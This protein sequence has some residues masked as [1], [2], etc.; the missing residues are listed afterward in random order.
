MAAP[1]L[2]VQ[3]TYAELLERCAAT[4]FDA[5]FSEDGSFTVKTIRG[6]RYWYF[7]TSTSGGRTQ[8]YV[9]PESPA[10]LEQIAHH[11][12]N[13]D[14]ERGRRTLVS[15]LV[16]SY[17]LPPPLPQV[18]SLLFA[19]ARAGTFRL[20]GVLV[21][22][23]A[24]HTYSAV[25]ARKLPSASLMT[26]D[27]DVAQFA[28]V[29]VAMGD[30]TPPMLKI[31]KDVDSSFREVLP[32]PGRDSAASYVGKGGLRVDFLTPNEGPDTDDPQ[33]LPALQTDALP[34]RFLDFLIHDAQP[35]VVLYSSGVYV[36]VPTPERFAVHKLILSIRRPAAFA[37][38]DKDLQ[39]AEALIE[40]LCEQRPGD[41]KEVWEEAYG[42]GPT[43]RK[44]LLNAMA[45]LSSKIRDQLLKAL[46]RT[47]DVLPEANVTFSDSV[48]HYD[49]S[50][51]VVSFIGQNFD[52]PVACAV[53]RETLEDHF[54]ADGLDR[55]GRMEVFR[56][57][58]PAIEELVRQKYLCWPIDEPGS[59]LL[60][61]MDVEKLREDLSRQAIHGTRQG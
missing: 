34:L 29:S 37:K 2:I 57:N 52:Q 49:F 47:R 61:S 51:E 60:A 58:R 42:R 24:Y 45:Q 1:Q 48:A 40:A 44:L 21:G 28:S 10:L 22:T 25:L 36:Q 32:P 55:K 12:Q 26:N 56:K 15:T 27:I 13:R 3:T 50:K 8:K 16:R 17:G 9:G 6:R 19:L 53:S 54:G 39:Q 59:I 33:N 5:A 18:G 20:R 30:H 35:A 31:L 41:L 43:W 7:Q 38:S 14:D 11:K 4:A 46:N 23:L